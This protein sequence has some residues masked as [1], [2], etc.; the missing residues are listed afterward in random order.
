MLLLSFRNRCQRLSRHGLGT[1]ILLAAVV[2]LSPLRTACAIDTRWTNPVSGRWFDA[3]HWTPSLPM[4]GDTAIVDAVGAPYR[5][6]YGIPLF[7]PAEV[8]LLSPDATLALSSNT[9]TLDGML[10]NTATIEASGSSRIDVGSFEQRGQLNVIGMQTPSTN[11]TSLRISDFTNEGLITLT[12]QG[13]SWQSELVADFVNEGAVRFEAGAGGQRSFRGAMTNRGNVDVQTATEFSVSAITNEA[14]FSIQPDA[15]LDFN[16]LVT[17]VWNQNAGVLDAQGVFA[18]RDGTFTFNFNGGTVRGNVELTNARLHLSEDATGGGA[19]SLIDGGRLTG[20][21]P[22]GT[23]VVLDRRTNSGNYSSPGGITNAGSV[24]MIGE[25]PTIWQISPEGAQ[26]TNTESGLITLDSR[27][28]RGSETAQIIASTVVNQGRVAARQSAEIR[29]FELFDHQGEIHVEESQVLRLTSFSSG[30]FEHTGTIRGPGLVSQEDG[31]FVHKSG[32]TLTP[33]QVVGLD[34]RSYTSGIGNY[35][36][37]GAK[38]RGDIPVGHTITIAAMDTSAT[39]GL[40][41][42]DL[43]GSIVNRGTII[44]GGV[45]NEGPG[46]VLFN[47]GVNESTGVVHVRPTAGEN[48]IERLATNHGRILV[49]GDAR[50]SG[51]TT[52]LGEIEV[53]GQLRGTGA[54]VNESTLRIAENGV[55]TGDFGATFIQQDGRIIVEGPVE[56]N[57]TLRINGGTIE[58]DGLVSARILELDAPSENTKFQVSDVLR[59]LPNA[60]GTAAIK[61]NEAVTVFGDVPHRHSITGPSFSFGQPDLEAAVSNAGTISTSRILV[62]NGHGTLTNTATGLIS[63][64]GS[65]SLIGHLIN[66]GNLHVGSPIGAATVLGSF[67][68]V[69]TGS[70]H[71]DLGG[72][73]PGVDYDQ[74]NLD[75]LS[76]SPVLGGTLHVSLLDGFLPAPSDTFTIVDSIRVL[77]GRFANLNDKVVLAEGAFDII[78]QSNQVRLTNFVPIPEPSSAVYAI[79]ALIAVVVTRIVLTRRAGGG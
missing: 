75:Q 22:V 47:N 46:A 69:A 62:G 9:I 40:A 23:H 33:V 19:F 21:I 32:E 31:F 11:R 66:Q 18:A 4:P 17:T 64:T 54:L 12:S 27:N 55:L 35:L 3:A 61:A 51:A 1:L 68:Q 74:L 57:G 50:I 36:I 8:R 38:L 5:I 60:G 67:T 15:R 16:R 45:D 49:E 20:F 52:N 26:L 70:L 2:S 59:Y 79:S 30:N 77:S 14:A 65:E 76:L 7:Q 63:L 34:Y 41:P 24:T 25:P 48:V 28:T 42:E 43:M 73:S 78:Y 13:G 71:I 53:R 56:W 10:L 29:F 37:R 44:L 58:G 6:A 72:R 39:A